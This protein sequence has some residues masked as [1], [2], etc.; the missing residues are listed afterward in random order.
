MSQKSSYQIK[1]VNGL[2][3]SLCR[4]SIQKAIRRSQTDRAMYFAVEIYQSNMEAYLVYSCAVI[5]SEEFSPLG[6]PAV[7][8]ALS[9]S[10][11]FWLY[12]LTERKKKKQR[13]ELRPAIGNWITTMCSEAMK[14]NRSGDDAWAWMEI[15]RKMGLQLEIE[16]QDKD[17][18]CSIGRK[19]GRGY[20]F[21]V[22]QASKQYPTISPKELG[23]EKDY[24]AIVNDW[25]LKNSPIPNESDWSEWD[26]DFP[27]N[28]IEEYPISDTQPSLK[29]PL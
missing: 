23:L 9:S 22:R 6:S 10:M 1:T 19:L 17:E 16:D 2:D 5:L 28:P 7:Y 8:S 3:L 13:T 18:H 12:A 29:D 11:N 24:T 25:Y 27:D 4:S 26:P 15:Q 14:K 20:K 21:W